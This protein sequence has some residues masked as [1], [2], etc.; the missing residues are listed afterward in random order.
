M[1]QNRE[2]S[3][4]QRLT[5]SIHIV[6]IAVSTTVVNPRFGVTYQANSEG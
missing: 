6:Y 5:N 4:F 3:D 1:G 2:F